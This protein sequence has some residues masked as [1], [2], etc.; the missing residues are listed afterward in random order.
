MYYFWLFI[1]SCG[2]QQLLF[3]LPLVTISLLGASRGSGYSCRS[4]LNVIRL[5][6]DTEATW[7][8]IPTHSPLNSF[9]LL[10]AKGWFEVACWE[11]YLSQRN[12]QT[13]PTLF[14]REVG[15]PKLFQEF[16]NCLV[17]WNIQFL[18]FRAW[19]CLQSKLAPFSL[20]VWL[21]SVRSRWS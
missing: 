20:L 14:G 19:I 5:L 1:H 3:Q 12:T 8:N 17:T 16:L 18:N 9:C 21:Q 4:A 10:S 6:S 11:C 2:V 13:V 7:H 15:W